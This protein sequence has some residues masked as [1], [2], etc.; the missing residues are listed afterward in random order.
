MTDMTIAKGLDFYS[1]Q[2]GVTSTVVY[3]VHYAA[4]GKEPADSEDM[5]RA[6]VLKY[7]VP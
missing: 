2:C 4:V 7:G 3:H 6:D 1:F 5:S